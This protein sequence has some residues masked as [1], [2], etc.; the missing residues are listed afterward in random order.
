MSIAARDKRAIS[1]LASWILAIFPQTALNVK[2]LLAALDLVWQHTLFLLYLHLSAATASGAAYMQ[3]LLAVISLTARWEETGLNRFWFG[4][5]PLVQVTQVGKWLKYSETIRPRPGRGETQPISY[6]SF[7]LKLCAGEGNYASL[8]RP[9]ETSA[10]LRLKAH[11]I[12]GD[13]RHW[14]IPRRGGQTNQ[15]LS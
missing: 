14:N 10:A 5:C 13:R 12:K 7:H 9:G 8:K 4:C 6:C 3:I 2:Q 1:Q 11:E 15:I